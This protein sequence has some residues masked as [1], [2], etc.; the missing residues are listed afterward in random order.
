MVQGNRREHE[1]RTLRRCA[2]P[3][4]YAHWEGFVKFAADCYLELVWRQHL[5]YQKLNSNFLALACRKVL[6]EGAQSDRISAHISIVEFLVFNQGN[7]A[8]FHRV[9]SAESNLNSDVFKNILQEIGLACEP[10]FALKFPL[11]DGSLLKN[12][13]DIA[14]G[15][16]VEVDDPTYTQLHD[17]VIDL[18]NL[19]ATS[20]ENAAAQK[21]YLRPATL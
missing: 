5:P 11:I 4:L 19:S 1:R 2:V 15:D 20:I 10:S 13:N 17:L 9:V 3:I 8:K 12:R 7:A 16:E 6:R 18:L 21:S 14:H